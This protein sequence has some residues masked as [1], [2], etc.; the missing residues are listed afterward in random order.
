MNVLYTPNE[1]QIGIDVGSLNHAVAVSD[2]LGNII[3]EFEITHTQK[4]FDHFFKMIGNI[5]NIEK[6]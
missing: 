4:G 2:G 3:N 5:A 6:I 1:L